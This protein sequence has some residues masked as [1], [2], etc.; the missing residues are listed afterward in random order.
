MLLL[1]R[2]LNR[3]KGGFV[4]IKSI[5]ILSIYII[6]LFTF[7]LFTLFIPPSSTY[8]QFDGKKAHYF[9]GYDSEQLSV[10]TGA[11]VK[12]TLAKLSN[13]G[14]EKTTRAYFTVETNDIRC[15]W[16]EGSAGTPT[17]SDG[18]FVPAGS[19]F[20]VLGYENIVNFG[21]IGATGTATVTVQYERLR[22]LR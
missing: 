20:Q 1:A 16:R 8:A 2:L 19:S 4:N 21:M 9:Q 14:S 6:L 15:L 13:S 22:P 12:F 18:I 5:T 10:T 11:V 17:T 3:K 7:T